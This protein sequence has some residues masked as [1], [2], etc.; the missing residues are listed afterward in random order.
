MK[1]MKATMAFTERGISLP[2]TAR[3]DHLF[4]LP[5][6]TFPPFIHYT[7]NKNMKVT[8]KVTAHIKNYLR[9]MYDADDDYDW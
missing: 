1:N 2:L 6:Q 8:I 5:P 9:F 7:K 3:N 4:T